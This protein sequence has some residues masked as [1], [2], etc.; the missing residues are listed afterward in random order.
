ME[1]LRKFPQAV[2]VFDEIEIDI[3]NA[4]INANNE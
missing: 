2:K 4:D 1:Y 3:D